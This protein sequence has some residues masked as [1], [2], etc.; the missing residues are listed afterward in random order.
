VGEG[1]GDRLTDERGRVDRDG[2]RLGE[3]QDLARRGA[4]DLLI[5]PVRAEEVGDDT[6]DRVRSSDRTP[7]PWTT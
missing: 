3:L 6:L 4:T 5:D 7:R 2:E 1:P